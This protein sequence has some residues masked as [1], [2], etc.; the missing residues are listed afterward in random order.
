MAV[1]V[2]EDVVVYEAVVVDEAFVVAE[3]FVVE[4]VIIVNNC[5]F[6]QYN[7]SIKEGL[8]IPSILIGWRSESV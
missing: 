5:Y 7:Q 8:P 1:V 4:E 3:A 6:N 2:D